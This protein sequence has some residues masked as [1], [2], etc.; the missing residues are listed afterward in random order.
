MNIVVL[1]G[2]TLNPGD[3][4]WGEFEALGPLTVYDR[5]PPEE[6]VRRATATEAVLVNKVRLD[7][8]V[9]EQL[10]ELRYVGVLATGYDIVDIAAARWRKVTVTNVPAYSTHS[11]VQMTLAHILNLTLRVGHHAHAVNQ[12]RWAA[13]EDFCFWDFP[14]VEIH[15]LTLGIIGFGRIGRALAHVAQALGM[16][17][18]VYDVARLFDLPHGIETVD[19][20]Q[21]LRQSDVVSLHCPLVPETRHLI[22]RERLALMKPSAILINTSR[23]PIVDEPALAEALAENRLAGAGGDVLTEEPPPA[24]HPL[25][26]L[27]NC[28]VTPHNAWATQASRRRLMRAAADNLR[29]FVTGR[30]QNVVS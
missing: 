10:P 25:I 5:T 9:L 17:V 1:D 29:A 18:L 30:P 20:E 27:K 6:V 22:N 3:L 13:A 19:L 14:L 4:S 23:G 11:V 26:G 24:D 21:L 12:G 15:G 16:R 28:Y 8:H 7:R 2:F